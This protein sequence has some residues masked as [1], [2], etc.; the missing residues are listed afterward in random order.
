M[1]VVIEEDRVLRLAQVLLDPA[2]PPAPSA[3][4]ATR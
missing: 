2:A 1:R 4:P 3:V